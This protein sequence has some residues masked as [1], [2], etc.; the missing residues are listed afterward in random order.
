MQQPSPMTGSGNAQ[1]GGHMPAARLVLHSK[2]GGV[3]LVQ[4]Q[5]DVEQPGAR[6]GRLPEPQVH[7]LCSTQQGVTRLQGGERTWGTVVF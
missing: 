6:V 1:V 2:H 4:A 5:P 3:D 7:R